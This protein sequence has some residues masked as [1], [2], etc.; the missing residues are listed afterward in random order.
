M[1]TVKWR[2]K[3][4]PRHIWIVGGSQ[5]IPRGIGYDLDF[6]GQGHSKI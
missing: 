5:V 1:V 6:G 2:G 4:I 3:D